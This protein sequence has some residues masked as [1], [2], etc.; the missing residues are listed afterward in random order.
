MHLAAPNFWAGYAGGDVT[1]RFRFFISI[2]TCNA[3]SSINEWITNYLVYS[4][5]ALQWNRK[6]QWGNSCRRILTLF[7][8]FGAVFHFIWCGNGVLTPLFSALHPCLCDAVT[9]FVYTGHLPLKTGYLFAWWLFVLFLLI[10]WVIWN[11]E[12]VTYHTNIL[13]SDRVT[14]HVFL[15]KVS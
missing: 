7:E 4:T 13:S 12:S 6:I 2:S 15:E 8:L 1:W 3:W 14:H 9:T 11:N 10:T 5:V